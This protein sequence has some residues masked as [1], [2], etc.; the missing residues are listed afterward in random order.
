MYRS[1]TEGVEEVSIVGKVRAI[2]AMV[3]GRRGGA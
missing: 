1:F 2:L 3:P